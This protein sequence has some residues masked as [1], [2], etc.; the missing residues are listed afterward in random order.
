MSSARPR[1]TPGSYFTIPAFRECDDGDPPGGPGQVDF[2]RPFRKIDFFNPK[3]LR[4]WA[5]T[6]SRPY[7][8][9]IGP[10]A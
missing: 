4:F 8:R 3:R 6:V 1:A 7:K 10:G 2:S 9:H 5:G